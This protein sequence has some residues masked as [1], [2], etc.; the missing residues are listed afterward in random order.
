MTPVLAE[1]TKHDYFGHFS[2]IFFSAIS[3]TSLQSHPCAFPELTEK[4]ISNGGKTA[5]VQLQVTTAFDYCSKIYAQSLTSLPFLL[6]KAEEV[7]FS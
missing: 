5:L 2:R 3:N 4:F 1:G 6:F 7:F